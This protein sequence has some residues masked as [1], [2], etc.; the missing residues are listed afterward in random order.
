MKPEGADDGTPGGW[1]HSVTDNEFSLRTAIGGWRGALES[2]LPGTVFVVVFLIT[3]NLWWTVALSA[4]T[5]VVF[6]LVRLIQRS[7]LTQALSGLI[8]VLIGVIWAASSGRVEN[9]YA[10]GLLT[11]AAYALVLVISALV[12]QPLVWWVLKLFWNLPRRPQTAA[13]RLLWRRSTWVTW[14]W[15]ALFAVRLAVQL[16]LY[17]S[18]NAAGLG[19]A[20][21]LLGLPLFAVTVWLTWVSLREFSPQNNDP[22]A[23]LEGQ[24][25]P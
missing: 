1:L 25:A 22:D 24:D 10:W 2:L 20:K 13:Q 14:L 19:I 11:N 4:V 17:Y 15:V 3:N 7:P 12:R 9:Y 5:S 18:R 23:A 21:L 8:G 6:C 16:P